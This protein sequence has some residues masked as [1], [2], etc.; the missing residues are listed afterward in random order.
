[1][2]KTSIEWTEHTVN[3]IR[4]RNKATGKV[5]HFCEKVSPGCGNCSA[6]TWNEKRFGTG[7]PFLPPHRAAVELFLDLTKLAEVLRRKKATT[8]FWCDMTDMFYEG[9]P[10]DWIDRCFATMALTPQHT[11]QVLT[12][13]A[14]RLEKYF[15]RSSCALE[16]IAALVSED[17]PARS[18]HMQVGLR[19]D[20]EA[21]PERAWPLPNVWLGVS[22]EDQL[23]ADERIP[24]LLNTPAAMRFLS[25]EP[26]L[27]PVDLMPWIKP[28]ECGPG[29]W[30]NPNVFDQPPLDWVIIGGE[31]GDDARPC[32][33][34]NVRSL[35]QQCKAAGIPVFNKQ[36]GSNCLERVEPPPLYA[37]II[38]RAATA[39]GVAIPDV[40]KRLKLKHSKGGDPSEWPKDLRVREFPK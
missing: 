11:H 23:R 4:A 15:S 25:C 17:N 31:S 37:E 20:D 10:E 35:V 5:G 24:H 7:L 27:G 3:P 12:K 39:G 18:I 40:F 30:D 14:D 2:S 13:R 21:E 16:R 26:L 1:M 9:Y 34:E 32:Q 8:Y 19:L 38:R 29:P 36:L 22:I 6:S 28:P 33:I